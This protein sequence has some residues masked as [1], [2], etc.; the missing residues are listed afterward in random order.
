MRVRLGIGIGAAAWSAIAFFL[1]SSPVEAAVTV[2]ISPGY[3][4]LVAG[5]TLQFSATVTGNSDTQVVWQVNNADGGGAASGTVTTSGLYTP[6]A[7]LPNP[8]LVTVTAQAHANR[9]ISATASITLLATAPT[10]QTYYVA[11]NG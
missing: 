4:Q 6:P 11:T 9:Q 5:Q 7:T 3:T 2:S 10:G 8:A 1:C